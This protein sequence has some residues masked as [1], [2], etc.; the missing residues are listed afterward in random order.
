MLRVA[1][2][3]CRGLGP[4]G[5]RGSRLRRRRG[6]GLRGRG[7]D[8]LRRAAGGAEATWGAV[9]TRTERRAVGLGRRRAAGH[10]PGLR[11]HERAD[12]LGG[13]REEGHVARALQRRGEHPLVL[14]ARAA[15][16]ARVDLAAVAD[17]AADA[18]DLF[19]VDLL[20][21]VDAERADL[22]ARA[23]RAAVAGTVPAA[24][25]ATTV[26]I[27]RPAAGAA[28]ATRTGTFLAHRDSLERDLVGI[29]RPRRSLLVACRHRAAAHP[30]LAVTTAAEHLEVVAADVEARL[31]DVVLVRPRPRAEAPV[32]EDL[33]ALLDVLLGDLR[34][35]TPAAHPV[36]VGLL[37][38]LAAAVRHAVH[39]DG[40]VTDRLALGGHAHLGVTPDVA[41]DLDLGHRCHLVFPLS[42]SSRRMTM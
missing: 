21:L 26:A 35:A 24:I 2:R 14:R 34:L 8:G 4:R 19:E 28:V 6:R 16:A 29:E 7:D 11:A 39:R 12:V 10:R 9:A 40:E 41:D 31:L 18:T 22:A 5:G 37:R 33:H 36:P 23:P 32:D 25:V 38:A 20:D 30:A 42:H 17:V 15:L 1:C 13:V 3:L 27:A